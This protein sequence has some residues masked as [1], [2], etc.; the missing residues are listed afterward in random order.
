MRANTFGGRGL[1]I[2]LICSALAAALLLAPSPAPAAGQWAYCKGKFGTHAKNVNCAVARKQAKRGYGKIVAEWN[3]EQK[4]RNK[5]KMGKWKCKNRFLL[6]EQYATVC[7]RARISG[8]TQVIRFF[9]GL[10]GLDA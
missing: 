5:F 4:I 9:W 3:A 2:G 1:L 7:K 10:G 8:N 6:Q